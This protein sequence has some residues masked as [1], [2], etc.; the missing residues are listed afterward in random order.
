MDE[1]AR[2]ERGTRALATVGLGRTD[3]VVWDVAAVWTGAGLDREELENV[4]APAE[5]NAAGV[6]DCDCR[7][8]S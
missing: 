4:A 3:D 8:N 2:R 6:C 5:L 7:Y 1:R